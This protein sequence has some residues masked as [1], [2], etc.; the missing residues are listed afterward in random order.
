LQN[1][2][3]DVRFDELTAGQNFIFE[4]VRQRVSFNW[5]FDIPALSNFFAEFGKL[6]YLA[7]YS[8]L[9][10]PTLHLVNISKASILRAFPRKIVGNLSLIYVF[11]LSIMGYLTL[12]TS[13]QTGDLFWFFNPDKVWHYILIPGV[14]LTS[15]VLFFAGYCIYAVFNLLSR[16]D[17]WREVPNPKKI[18]LARTTLFTIIAIRLCKITLRMFALMN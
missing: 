4:L 17:I 3:A 10:I 2:P 9:L 5:L 8:L 13:L 1:Y 15:V 16:N 7:P 18:H 6:L 12:S 11:F 14:I